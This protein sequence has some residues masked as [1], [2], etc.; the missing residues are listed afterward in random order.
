MLFL[1]DF[2]WLPVVLAAATGLLTWSIFSWRKAKFV[3]SRREEL[4]VLVAERGLRFA[5]ENEFQLGRELREFDLLKKSYFFKESQITNVLS[6][7]IGFTDIFLFDFTFMRST[8][9]SAVPVRQTV[10]FAKN[11]DWKLPDFK[12]K[13]EGWWQK[14]QQYFGRT[15]IDFEE[16]PDFSNRF[17]LTG[18][19]EEMI[20][21]SF[22]PEV[23]AFFEHNPP[24]HV[25]GNNYYLI[26]YK[27]GVVQ[28]SAEAQL[29]YDDCLRLSELL[30][31][32]EKEELLKLAEIR[33]PVENSIENQ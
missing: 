4:A 32:G 31:K 29:F 5:D 3:A 12:L 1:V 7:S 17:W 8:G 27:P 18:E 10:F 9:K 15:D 25:E 13:P 11:R 19:F 24:I 2:T 16:N 33:V 6:T 20:R 26:A 30:Q 22:S 21:T 14:I 23:R 28:D